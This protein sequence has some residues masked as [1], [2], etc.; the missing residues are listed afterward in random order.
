M[1]HPATFPCLSSSSTETCC[2]Q[3]SLLPSSSPADYFRV[4]LLLLFYPPPRKLS[5][6]SWRMVW[7]CAIG[8]H[9]A[10]YSISG[11][12]KIK[13][14]FLGL[15]RVLLFRSLFEPLPIFSFFLSLRLSLFLSSQFITAATT[16]TRVL[17][18]SG[19]TTATRLLSIVCTH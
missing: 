7:P 9:K 19:P 11:E 10:C 3:R 15:V 18:Y 14:L 13:L 17:L 8:K 2:H 16:K 1:T 6:L 5:P 12:V 4:L